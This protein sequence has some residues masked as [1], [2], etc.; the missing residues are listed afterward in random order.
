MKIDKIKNLIRNY[1]KEIL[2]EQD[3]NIDN[4]EIRNA[5]KRVEIAKQKVE[6]ER[7]RE[8]DSQIKNADTK[9]SDA[10]TDDEREKFNQI[11]KKLKD[12]K[13]ASQA[14]YKASRDTISGL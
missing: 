7:Q 4:D 11:I 6:T 3:D 2:S 5:R 13:S 1:V 8:I 9:R 12:K 14:A 10:K